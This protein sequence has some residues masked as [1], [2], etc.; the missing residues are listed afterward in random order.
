MTI[1]EFHDAL[2]LED[3]ITSIDDRLQALNTMK[4]R[5]TRGS[6]VTVQ[7]EGQ[8]LQIDSYKAAVFLPLIEALE[9]DWE[10]QRRM[11]IEELKKLGVDYE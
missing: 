2:D 6:Y 4:E 8:H 5:I 1:D 7:F 3:T 11:S 10:N 9:L